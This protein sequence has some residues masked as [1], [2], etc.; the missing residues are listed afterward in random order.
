M[1][2]AK[3]FLDSYPLQDFAS[4][5]SS[6]L[7]SHVIEPHVASRL[8][9]LFRYSCWRIPPQYHRF[10][11]LRA[12]KVATW[13]QR[14]RKT[15]PNLPQFEVSGRFP[16]L[17][18]CCKT[19]DQ[20][21]ACDLYPNSIDMIVDMFSIN[22]DYVERRQENILVVSVTKTKKVKYMQNLS[23]VEAMETK[24]KKTAQLVSKQY[25]IQLLSDIQE[26]WTVSASMLQRDRMWVLC[27]HIDFVSHDWQTQADSVED[28]MVFF[29]WLVSLPLISGWFCYTM[30]GRLEVVA[31]SITD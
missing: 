3:V 16:Q 27:L 23:L 31:G 25:V 12:Q 29:I 15:Q 5:L 9:L 10:L 26:T 24:A 7:D 28:W 18:I 22:L 14:R 17:W 1:L 11:L 13:C 2:N 30:I 21:H 8:D 4:W 19:L 6:F 20:H